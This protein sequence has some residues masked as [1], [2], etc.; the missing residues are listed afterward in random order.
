MHLSIE[1][2]HF[3]NSWNKEKNKNKLVSAE[4]VHITMNQQALLYTSPP[5]Q[6]SV[7]TPK[8]FS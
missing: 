6:S 4:G 5:K 8:V 1:G 3:I 7:S 2:S